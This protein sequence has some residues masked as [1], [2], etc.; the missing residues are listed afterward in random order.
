MPSDNQETVN[1]LTMNQWLKRVD[2][3]LLS[4]I[5]MTSSDLPDFDIWNMWNDG[6]SPEDGAYECLIESDMGIDPE[7]F[8]F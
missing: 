5:G 1:G 3:I 8:G 2:A 4:R 7:D 6:C